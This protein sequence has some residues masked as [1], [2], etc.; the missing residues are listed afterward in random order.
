MQ[1][2]RLHLRVLH[3]PLLIARVYA[4]ATGNGVTTGCTQ[5][6]ACDPGCYGTGDGNCYQCGA[7]FWKA[8]I[9]IALCK[10]CFLDAGYFAGSNCL[11][12]TGYSQ[13]TC[14][15]GASGPDGGPCAKCAAGKYKDTTG[16]G[17]CINCGVGFWT[18]T[19]GYKLMT[20]CRSCPAGSG[21]SCSGTC[22]TSSG[23]TCDI[24]LTGPDNGL[25]CVAC[26]AGTYKSTPGSAACTT[27]AA[28]L[29]STTTGATAVTTCVLCPGNSNSPS[30][31]SACTCNAGFWGLDGGTCTV[32]TVGTFKNTS[33][34]GACTP[35]SRGTWAVAGSSVCVCDAGYGVV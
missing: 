1:H 35:C 5:T 31:S 20:D 13:C 14:N 18:P 30:A 2:M 28:G 8:N 9:G 34:S 23:C 11:T 7:G 22:G 27:C 26:V 17:G 3:F 32:C 12:C 29:Y 6:T 19:T 25:A 21:A 33:G 15:K 16:S 10:D 4:P 24:G